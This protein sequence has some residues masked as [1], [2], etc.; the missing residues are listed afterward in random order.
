M[1]DN[2]YNSN[3]EN[4]PGYTIITTPGNITVTYPTPYYY[5]ISA[6]NPS[7]IN[8]TLP[9]LL[10]P[11]AVP[12]GQPFIVENQDAITVIVNNFENVF[13]TNINSGK[14]TTFYPNGN[15]GWSFWQEDAPVIPVI[16]TF[17]LLF[18]VGLYQFPGVSA[19]VTA[20][21]LDSNIV[22][23]TVPNLRHLTSATNSLNTEALPV[24]FTPSANRSGIYSFF[25]GFINNVGRF[26]VGNDGIIR[27][28]ANTD[29]LF[30][31]ALMSN[32]GTNAQSITYNL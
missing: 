31:P 16:Q 13:L 3:D 21:R 19:S 6:A 1:S 9:S 17:N 26:Q 28:Y 27:F 24:A 25:D 29:Q 8:F 5:K 20:Q 18:G 15:G 4:S 2:F 14:R 32:I 10:V 12:Q 23:I 7:N 30:F 22:L 11:Q